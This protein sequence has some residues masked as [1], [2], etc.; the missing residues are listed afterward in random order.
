MKLT[1]FK[2]AFKIIAAFLIFITGLQGV[3]AFEL[4][5][6]KITQ[7]INDADLRKQAV[8]SVSIRELDSDKAIYSKNDNKL[9]HPASTLKLLTFAPILDT[10]GTDYKF[11]TTIFADN[12]NNLYIKLGADPLLTVDSLKKLAGELKNNYNVSKINKI[13]IDDTIIDKTPYLDGW[14]SDDFYPNTPMISPYTLNKNQTIVKIFVS[15]DKSRIEISQSEPYK[16]SIINKLTLGTKND[17]KVMQDV[18]EEYKIGN[19]I[20][21]EGTVSGNID[22]EIPV[23]NPKYNFI[24]NL[25]DAFSS[26]KVPYK[27]E[28]YFAKTPSGLK[29][30][31][32]ISHSIEEVGS[33]ILKNSDN[34]SSE[35]AF[36]VAG[37][38][39]A[40]KQ[41]GT[42]A[43]GIDMFNNYY[44]GLG[45]DTGSIKIVDASGV[46]R[47]NLFST[48]WISNA[49]FYI[50]NKTNIKNYMAQ[51][52]E[53][54]L[55]KRLRTIKS[56]VWA[57]T[58]TQTALS[59]LCGLVKAKNKELVF[60]IIISNFNEKTSVIKAFE[61]D[62][63]YTIWGL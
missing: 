31:A 48:S 63:V 7:T 39:Y 33:S 34:F 12:N 15:A 35:V 17:V 38:K 46:S 53:G 57:K 50:F 47:Y 23:S 28:F 9:L 8:V 51:P 4:G 43:N 3:Q 62:L 60:S 44:K 24:T 5:T 19:I 42:T 16:H 40:N 29:K 37:A 13:Y 20:N 10:L 27:R 26:A 32:E 56:D 58:G 45:L 1:M 14:T 55:S 2:T 22:I 21:L 25:N 11:A 54:T 36:R 61:D 41:P 18:Q 49:L 6:G 30:V 59:A 52:G